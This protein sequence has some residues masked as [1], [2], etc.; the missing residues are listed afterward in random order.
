[1]RRGFSDS[2]KVYE[3]NIYATGVAD[4]E[5]AISALSGLWLKKSG[6]S[7]YIANTALPGGCAT[8]LVALTSFDSI[9]VPTYVGDGS[10][11]KQVNYYLVNSNG[12]D[13]SAGMSVAINVQVSG[14]EKSDLFSGKILYKIDGFV[15]LSTGLL[16]TTY[17]DTGE[18]L[19]YIGTYNV[20]DSRFPTVALED[21]VKVG[22]AVLLSLYIKFDKIQFNGLLPDGYIQVLPQIIDTVGTFNPVGS[23][24]EKGII[25]NELNK[26]RVT[27]NTGLSVE[28]KPGSG[29]VKNY[30]F[31]KP[32]SGYVYLLSGNTNNQK[33]YVNTNGNVYLNTEELS[34]S[35]LRAI[36]DTTTKES[37]VSPWTDYT[38]ASL[39]SSIQVT[40]TFPCDSELDC[41]IRCDYPDVIAGMTGKFN[42]SKVNI[43][44]Q[45]QSDGEIRKFT[46]ITIAPVEPQ[47]VI[48]NDWSTGTV[49]TSIPN[50]SQSFYDP[51]SNTVTE[52]VSTG[53]FTNDYYRVSHSFV[54]D[55]STV[56]DITHSVANGC[57]AEALLTGETVFGSNSFSTLQQIRDLTTV[58]DGRLA[59]CFN[60]EQLY[61]Y[62]SLSIEEDDGFNVLEPTTLTGRWLNQNKNITRTYVRNYDPSL[63]DDVTEGYRKG[64]RWVN[65][66]TDLERV[67]EYTLIDNTENNA[68]WREVGDAVGGTTGGQDDVIELT[69]D[70]TWYIGL[71][72]VYERDG[73]TIGNAINWT[74]LVDILPKVKYNNHTLTLYFKAGTYSE[75]VTGLYNDNFYL[76]STIK[77]G[78]LQITAPDWVGI[79]SAPSVTF[80]YIPCYNLV[81]GSLRIKNIAITDII[82]L[83]DCPYCRI[84]H[85]YFNGTNDSCIYAY[86]SYLTI[87]GWMKF[88][89]TTYDSFVYVF[90]KTTITNYGVYDA[91]GNTVTFSVAAFDLYYYS[92]LYSNATTGGSGSFVG[93]TALINDGTSFYEFLSTNDKPGNAS[94]EYTLTVGSDLKELQPVAFSGS[95]DDLTDKPTFTDTKQLLVSADD[96]T[97]GYLS[98]KL[99]EGTGITITVNN[100]G[101]DETLT[102]ESTATGGGLTVVYTTDV[103]LTASAGNIYLLD[104]TTTVNLPAGVNGDQIGFA[105]YA[106]NFGSSN[107]TINRNGTDTVPGGTSL[108]LSSDGACVLFAFHGGKW[109]LYSAESFLDIGGSGGSGHT[110]ADEGTPLTARTTLDFVGSGVT[111]TDDSGNDKT[112]VTI[113]GDGGGGLTWSE[114]TGTSQTIAADNGYIANNASLV[115]LSLP[116]TCA[117]G[118]TFA[119]QGKGAGGWRISQAVGQQIHFGEVSSTSGTGGY[120]ESTSPSLQYAA[121]E[122]ICITADTIFAVRNSSGVINVN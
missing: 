38:F 46:N 4:G 50:T 60:N 63:T 39:N 6:F 115:T 98:T 5:Y 15:D 66:N 44:V 53:N 9:E 86:N 28:V 70:T 16:R 71:D 97:E 93:K 89:Q 99:V 54:W 29:I 117:I 47:N 27:P 25:Y 102:I 65:D 55:G 76:F 48:I 73:L 14:Y 120:I 80:E 31:F 62:N 22:E 109:V 64:D 106:N 72:G 92:R 32:Q 2:G 91:G 19:K 100:D 51:L 79:W 81:S 96:T 20:Y 40:L 111:V 26:R 82:D 36:V 69:E 78:T 122:L 108:T 57:I 3:L 58:Y 10:P 95:Y 59:Y 21:V 77:Q 42:V 34:D 61:L 85:L 49:V 67:K 105:D 94:A 23:L 75:E 43:Y 18:P 1:M 116:T 103:T 87:T 83:S 84:E 7:N 56:S 45:R 104:G 112:I 52:Q 114:V 8:D 113:N 119:V 13:L 33:L 41:T 74:K 107:L 35:I 101:G 88:N 17:Y 24:F 68:I 30:A 110:I 11:S 118:K 37:K 12:S 90:D 121:V